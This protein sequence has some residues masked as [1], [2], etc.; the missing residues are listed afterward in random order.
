MT[1]VAARPRHA[2]Q[3]R[4]ITAHGGVAGLG[5]ERYSRAAG[6]HDASGAM[7]VEPRIPPTATVGANGHAAA[8]TPAVGVGDGRSQRVRRGAAAALTLG[9]LGV[10]FGDIG[11]SP[12]YSMQTVFAIDNSI[13]KPTHA[14][15]Y[16]VVSLIFWAVTIIVSLKYVTFI[17]RADNDG[18]GGI[19]A[20]ISLVQRAKLR[21][22]A[23]IVTLIVL[24]IFGASLFYG[25]GMITPA[26]SVLS[27][28]EGMK[29]AT[30]SLEHLVIPITLVV[31]SC[32]FA[33]Q[34]FG[35][36]A[37]G[38]LFGPIMAVWFGV[39][40]LAGLNE[41]VQ[42]PGIVQALSPTYGAS[43]LVHHGKVA[44]V[45][46]GAVVLAVTG[47]EALYADM[48]HF[49]RPPIRRAWFFLVFPA[50]TLN[51]LGQGA[52]IL[53]DP[54]AIAN[55]FFLL[56]PHWGRVPMVLL[57]TVATIIAS[58]A[59]ISGAF[60]V[61]RQAVQLGFLPRL[62]IH[63][64]SHHEG[65]VYVP[66][67]NWGICIAVIA[68]VVGFG[69]SA[70]LAHAYGIA[71]TGTLTID[72]ILFF[73]VVR[74]LW[75]KPWPTVI[76]G[77][78]AFLIVDLAFLSAN[79]SKVLHGG[80]FPLAIALIVFTLL[81]TWQR[82]RQIVTANRTEEEGPLRDF[83]EELHEMKPPVYR[84]PGT[85]VFLNPGKKTTPLGMRALVEHTNVLPEA[86]VIMS[87][88]TMKVPHVPEAE[89]L[90]IDELGYSDDGII[91]IT[92][93]IGFQDDPDV[94]GILWQAADLGLECRIDA[95]SAS[96]YLSRITIVRSGTP[97]MRAWR[98]RLF[99][100]MARNAAS[101]IEYFGLPSERTVVM[102]G[103]IPC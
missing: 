44:F 51:Y 45:A 24:G 49:G 37:V 7:S 79:L 5:G 78:A 92:A 33:I 102:G 76:I 52:L 14:G 59:V 20:L 75:R 9:A 72:T 87:V 90:V 81:T 50:L 29:V 4:H 17:M 8:G 77:A 93:R 61:T 35:T 26:I 67:I 65:Q 100:A 101:P 70:N 55:P 13:V 23:A 18:E 84:S 31:L 74:A 21:S 91:H 56:I 3:R 62:N 58:Q 66:A 36:G 85:A 89:R 39:L 15:V 47:A 19:M 80:W 83:I 64:T 99:I 34:R 32:L 43:F 86:V 103:H 54:K 63:H 10:V 11:T 71:V 53:H 46:L 82:G 96:Y 12:L 27:A 57:A 95:D 94:P 6:A 25:D 2:I 22:R 40:A 42:H 88:E 69:S 60:S 16:G 38:R 28:V 68:L 73:F 1:T 97:G 98:K 41:V 48:G 30:P